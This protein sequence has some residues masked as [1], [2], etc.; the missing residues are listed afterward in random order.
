MNP[1]LACSTQPPGRGRIPKAIGWGRT[2]RNGSIMDHDDMPTWL[3]G[4]A[5]RVHTLILDHDAMPRFRSMVQQWIEQDG[6]ARERFD[7]W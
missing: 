1:A 5:S 6:A 4:F 2:A 3:I 7:E